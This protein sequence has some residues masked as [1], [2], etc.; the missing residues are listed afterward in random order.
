MTK[1]LLDQTF[2]TVVFDPSFDISGHVISDPHARAIGFVGLRLM[3]D[4]DQGH[5]GP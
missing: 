3:D 5:L 2:G 4:I 1:D